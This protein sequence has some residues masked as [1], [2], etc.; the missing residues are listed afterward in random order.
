MLEKPAQLFVDQQGAVRLW[1]D[2]CER[3]FGYRAADVIGQPID[4]LIVPAYRERHWRGF[5]AT[6][7][8]IET[9][10][11]QAVGNIPVLHAD[12]SIHAHPFRQIILIDAFGRSTG[13]VVIFSE[14]LAPG[15]YN[16][17]PDLF[18]EV[19]HRAGCRQ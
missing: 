18:I 7:A 4:F 16:G 5:Q 1:D 17:L 8:R 19:F 12:G 10:R 6:M 13:A 15:A 9:D 2:D 14:P 11:P 3:L